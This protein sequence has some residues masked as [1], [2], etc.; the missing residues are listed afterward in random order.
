MATVGGKRTAWMR[1]ADGSNDEQSV[2]RKA[3]QLDEISY[4]S[5]GRYT[6]LRSQGTSANTRKLLIAPAGG[7]SVPRSLVKSEYDNFG[8]QISPDGKWIAYTSNESKQNEVYVRPFPSVDSARWTISVNGGTEPVWSRN[9][10][11]LFFRTPGGDMMAVQVAAGNVFV[12][13]TPVKLFNNPHLLAD[14]YHQSYDVDSGDR[15]IMIRS[16]QKNAQTLGV[17]INWGAEISR[18]SSKKKPGG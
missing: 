12:P 9:G 2:N 7:D 6:V 14:T 10:R 13:S 17:V 16:S 1:R 5:D 4:S 18:L 3:P 15:F 11:Q 8:A